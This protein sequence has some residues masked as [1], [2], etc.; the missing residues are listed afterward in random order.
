MTTR[1]IQ[2]R[3]QEL[4]PDQYFRLQRELLKEK[5]GN[6]QRELLE[7]LKTNADLVSWIEDRVQTNEGRTLPTFDGPLTEAS[8]K[9]PTDVQEARMY[10][11]WRDASP[12]MACR[13]SFWASVTLEHIRQ[14]KIAEATWLAANGG[15]TET[16]EERVD[17]ALSLRSNESN[18]KIVDACVRTM[19]RRLSGLPTARGN[20]TVFVNPSFGRAWW[21][22]RLVSNILENYEPVASRAALLRVVRR[23][24]QYWENLVT[25]IVS[26]GS[27]FGSADIQAALINSLA[28]RFEAEPD[29]PLR[30]ASTLNTVLRRF[31]NLTA[32]QEIGILPFTEIGEIVDD[33][34]DRVQQARTSQ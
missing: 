29:T 25:M 15:I 32:P 23:N 30:N 33:L 20:R 27:V 11:L 10:E 21:R 8:F 16:G 5:G 9:D 34:L 26:R 3:Y 6:L 18:N 22:E 12:R 19:F 31:S 2:P 24:Q 28:N 7:A 14:G 4:D 13:T 17:H 1:Q